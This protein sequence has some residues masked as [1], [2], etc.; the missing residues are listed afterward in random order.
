M[1]STPLSF[2]KGNNHLEFEHSKP[3]CQLIFFLKVDLQ[4]TRSLSEGF[5]EDIGYRLNQTRENSTIESL[6]MSKRAPYLLYLTLGMA[7]P[8]DS[9]PLSGVRL[10]VTVTA[11]SVLAQQSSFPHIAMSSKPPFE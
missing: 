11:M 4:K 6:T 2:R 8:W 3:L 9:R 7:F 5:L 1:R 10:P